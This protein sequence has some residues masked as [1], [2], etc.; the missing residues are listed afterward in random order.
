MKNTKQQ[1]LRNTL[2]M[3][4]FIS[5]LCLICLFFMSASAL[6]AKSLGKA[7]EQVQRES[8]GKVISA[9]T[10]QKGDRR[11]HNIRVLTPE[12]RVKRYRVDA[13]EN[14]KRRPN[15]PAFNRR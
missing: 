1:N 2:G 4:F 3:R 12:G 14:G 13:G 11:V 15:A 8:G 7:V 5:L 6:M 10:V 9:N